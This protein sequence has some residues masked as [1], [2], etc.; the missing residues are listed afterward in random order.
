M[1][2]SEKYKCQMVSIN[3]MNDQINV[4]LPKILH[5]DAKNYAGANGFSSIQELM[6]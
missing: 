1:S 6:K 4:R 3:I 2:E 5:K